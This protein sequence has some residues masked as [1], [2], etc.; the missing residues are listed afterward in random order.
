VPCVNPDGTLT[1]SAQ[2]LL[3]L[4]EKPATPEEIAKR[5]DRPL[6]SVRAS[7][8]ELVGADLVRAEGGQFVLTERGR[9][10]L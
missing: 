5:L 8:R 10:R 2:A 6:F 3:R 1:E 7:L 4:L 9:S